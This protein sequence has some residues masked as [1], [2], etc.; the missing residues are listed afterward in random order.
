MSPCDIYAFKKR[1]KLDALSFSW[2]TNKDTLKNSVF[3]VETSDDINDLHL[4]STIEDNC[5][6]C[7]SGYKD[8]PGHYGHYSFFLPLVHP[9][10]T[11]YAKKHLTA[12]YKKHSK[13]FVKQ[14]ILNVKKKSESNYRCFTVFDLPHF[15]EEN[16][17]EEFPF[18]IKYFPISPP[19][20][21]PTCT[22]ISS[23]V[24]VSQNDITH[25]IGS[26]IRIDKTL[27]KSFTLNP[28]NKEEHIRILSRLQLAFTLLFYPPPGVR[29][30][31]ELSCLTDRLR[32]KDGRMRLSLLGKRVEFSSRAVISGNNYLELDQVGVPNAIANALTVP[33]Y[34][35]NFNFDYLTNLLQK[36]KIKVIQRQK[37]TI[38]PKY[39]HHYLQ[40][41][42][43]VH[44]YLL[45]DD[46]V[47][48]NRQPSLWAS[49]IMA[50]RV[51]R[52]PETS[53]SDAQSIQLNVDITPGFNADFDG[54][55]MCLY[56]VQSVE[57]RAELKYLMSC[58][59]HLLIAGSGV[60]QDS[61]LGVYV[62]TMDDKPM[63]KSLFFDCIMWIKQPFYGKNPFKPPHTSR[64]LI[65]MLCPPWLTVEP[66]VR[67]GKVIASLNKKIVKK[68][69]LPL[70]HKHNP[71]LA[72]DFLYSLQRIA[73]EYFRRRGFSV[74]LDSLLPEKKVARSVRKLNKQMDKWEMGCLARQMKNEQAVNAK[75]LFTRENKF[76]QLTSEGSHAKGSLMNIISMKSSVGQQ[77]VNGDIIKTYRRSNYGNRTLSSDKF[78]E[79]NIFTHGYIQGDFLTG[80]N[81]KELFL[82]SISSRVN[83]LDTAL[84]TA[85]SGYASRKIWKNLE[86]A[87]IVNNT[88]K[89][90]KMSIRCSGKILR[91]DIDA[92]CLKNRTL[93]TGFPIGL[94]LSQTVGQNI[95]QLTLNTFHNVGGA[96]KVVEGVP[97]LEA[98]INKW[99]KKQAQ[100]AMLT[101]KMPCYEIHKILMK[102]DC[103]HLSDVFENYQLN[104]NN[105]IIQ[106]NKIKTIRIRVHPWQIIET[107]HRSNI[108]PVC[109]AT[110][111]EN[112]Q[113]TIKVPKCN[114]NIKQ[115]IVNYCKELIIRGEEGVHVF[116]NDGE[117]QIVGRTLKQ[118]FER[119]S[120]Y[121]LQLQSNNILEMW[122]TLGI[123]A[124]YATL[125]K[126][127]NKVFNGTVDITY[128][129]ILA[130][131][132]CFL[133]KVSA[134]T[135]MG[136][137][138]FYEDNTWKGMSFERTLKTASN[139]AQ[140]NIKTKFDGLSER[141]IVNKM[142]QHGTG[143]IEILKEK[144]KCGHDECWGHICSVRKKR[145]RAQTFNDDEPWILPP[146]ENSN[147]F[148]GGG[149]LNSN[150]MGS[151]M[152][153]MM[154]GMAPTQPKHWP[155]MTWNIP[156]N[157]MSH[158]IQ[159]NHSGIQANVPL[160][161][162][163]D[164]FKPNIEHAADPMSPQY[165][166]FTAPESPQYDPNTPAPE[167]PQ[168]DPNTRY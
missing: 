165:D 147:P 60:V 90:G 91:F 149:G 135:R 55:E 78:S 162:Q 119:D 76:I 21:R 42:D 28:D 118:E 34:V 35:C 144:A 140:N 134:T 36:G 39:G 54:D 41:G 44:R 145:K 142:V 50:L 6:T 23:K 61:A 94:I 33:E 164:P 161:P 31:R 129:K 37:R 117:M 113:I 167:S 141:I 10:R 82:H 53:S 30:S 99:E 133:G 124:A 69:I 12:A 139:A 19:C 127:L 122:K 49:S 11:P 116:D 71:Q 126:E 102:R 114:K 130:E 148:V 154:G 83:L 150:T 106:C 100:Q 79:N 29:E 92:N 131:Y 56:C 45:D 26:L 156:N 152:G 95:M 84:K 101:M 22:T 136:I 7:F 1:K 105:I 65:S 103:V 73:S 70:L 2:Y 163:Y 158:G 32:G 5:K 4:G 24:S 80:L 16:I 58:E 151:M 107:I 138:D 64:N 160:S 157:I 87:V 15:N 25:R 112:Y 38:D 96:N 81:P 123:E 20:L 67:N 68:K 93:C 59:N 62:L 110:I 14:N 137:H 66:Y 97:R 13:F 8:C 74:G 155:A 46:Y 108:F 109:K 77:Y 3:E 153:G 120:K 168:Y 115:E 47:L 132:M 89:G 88:C 111:N 57:A 85:N 18:L 146:E 75:K 40:I 72:L 166:P 27:R 143:C 86:D 52:I 125:V 43:V 51:K 104:K 63:A 48:L 121:C 128:F 17:D 9:L 159:E 98:L